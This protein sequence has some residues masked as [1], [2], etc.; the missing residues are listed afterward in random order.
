MSLSASHPSEQPDSSR[1]APSPTGLRDEHCEAG[2]E[3]MRED[4]S[5]GLTSSPASRTGRQD[6]WGLHESEY[7]EEDSMRR[8]FIASPRQR[9]RLDRNVD[10]S[11]PA[12]TA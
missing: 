7:L 11:S 4:R 10:P 8:V 5:G 6:P 2:S 9:Y 3:L 1:C 12:D